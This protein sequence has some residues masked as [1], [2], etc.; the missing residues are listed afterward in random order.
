MNIDFGG[1]LKSK[2]EEKN[3]TQS[4]LANMIGV[5]PPQISRII[6]GDRSTRTDTLI[7]IAHALKL[8]PIT[9]FRKAGLLPT[10][11]NG[12][13]SIRFADWQ[14]LLEQL[15]RL[16]DAYLAGQW[17]LPRYTERKARIDAQIQQIQQDALEAE[18]RAINRAQLDHAL[19]ELRAIPD[20]HTWLTES[21]PAEVNARLHFLIDR[22][23]ISP[24]Q[25]EITLK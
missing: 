18:T 6:S 17:D 14:F 11:A 5:H 7:A 2:L 10:P 8:S 15:T 3:I 9:I 12:D 21:D 22:I 23:T 19:Q 1:W 20:L 4:E 25:I 16:E 13:E 24:D